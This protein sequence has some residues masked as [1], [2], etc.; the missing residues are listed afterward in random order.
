MR[1]AAILVW[2]LCTAV[3]GVAEE[4]AAV[5]ISGSLAG[6]N[7]R[8]Q[9]VWNSDTNEY[10]VAWVN[11]TE[12]RVYARIVTGAGTPVGQPAVISTKAAGDNISIAYDSTA[13][14]YLVT[15]ET[16]S[17]GNVA[18]SLFAQRVGA[19]GRAVGNPTKLAGEQKKLNWRSACIYNPADDVY[20]VVWSK[21]GLMTADGGNYSG[22]TD[23]LYG[24]F[25]GPD[26][27]AVGNAF[28]IRAMSYQSADGYL[29]HMSYLGFVVRYQASK[30]RYAIGT[31]HV[32]DTEGNQD[33]EFLATDRNGA[34]VAG[35]FRVNKSG[36][37]NRSYQ[38]GIAEKTTTGEWLAVWDDIEKVGDAKEGTVYHRMLNTGGAPKGTATATY[39]NGQECGGPVAAFDPDKG[40][41]LVV[42]YADSDPE[43]SD[44]NLDVRGRFVSGTG[45][46]IGQGFNI[47]ASGTNEAEHCVVYNAT[48]K[49]YFVVYAQVAGS[50]KIKILGTIVNPS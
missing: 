5:V 46:V 37:G 19:D 8:T 40:N 11:R 4:E 13:G 24:R 9:V 25:V 22:T 30:K 17:T 14:E 43:N 39:Y 20:L 21:E 31:N 50:D 45:A 12:K 6:K 29:V 41:F 15:W 33:T 23:G 34:L 16:A 10:L 35:P 49:K 7:G 26:G 18:T 38:A 28:L 36:V 47:A 42:H 27:K 1:F 44:T 48:E 32:V 2:V 3:S